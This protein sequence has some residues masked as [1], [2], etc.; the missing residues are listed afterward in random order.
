MP[1][2]DYK[3]ELCEAVEERVKS[4]SD[5]SPEVCQWCGSSMIR[6]LSTPAIQFKGSGFYSTDNRKK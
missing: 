2:Y 3:C 1:R 5:N 4:F 6:Q